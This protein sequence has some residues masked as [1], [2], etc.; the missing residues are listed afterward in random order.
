MNHITKEKAELILANQHR[1]EL[2]AENLL[3]IEFAK[4]IVG[5]RQS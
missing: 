3:L 1:M 2:T 4:A 5:G